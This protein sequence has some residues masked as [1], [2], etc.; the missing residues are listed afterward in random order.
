MMIRTNN[1]HKASIPYRA[2]SSKESE[3]SQL[4]IAGVDDFILISTNCNG[5]IYE[6]LVQ[7]MQQ[8]G[9]TPDETLKQAVDEW[10]EKV[11]KWMKPEMNGQDF[12]K[13]DIKT[14]R[15]KGDFSLGNFFE[16]ILEDSDLADRDAPVEIRH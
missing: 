7:I 11:Q 8:K 6:K 2:V 12:Y 9:R 13:H 16:L 1:W 3:D 15:T 10:V 14:G 5:K 4:M